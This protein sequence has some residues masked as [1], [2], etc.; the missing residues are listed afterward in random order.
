[1]VSSD[2]SGYILAPQVLA[3]GSCLLLLLGV[4]IGKLITSSRVGETDS[5]SSRTPL[6]RE[7]TSGARTTIIHGIG[8][9]QETGSLHGDER[10]T[11]TGS[12]TDTNAAASNS[13]AEVY[14]PLTLSLQYTRR[15]PFEYLKPLR[16]R[17]PDGIALASDFEQWYGDRR[18]LPAPGLTGRQLDAWKRFP[19]P[20]ASFSPK[21]MEAALQDPRGMVYGGG[22]GGLGNQLWAAATVLAVAI[23]TNRLPVVSCG[24]CY[25]HE[26]LREFHC[27]PTKRGNI[28]V[29]SDVS[30]AWVG[31]GEAPQAAAAD[32]DKYH[33]ATEKVLTMTGWMQ[34]WYNFHNHW[35]SV[36]WALRPRPD[37]QKLAQ[38]FLDAVVRDNNV[39]VTE[40]TRIVT[41]HLRRGDYVGK[42]NIHG[43]L[44]KEYYDRGLAMIRARVAMAEPR[45]AAE[46][47]VVV[48]MTEQENVQ[49]CQENMKWGMAD[50]V[51]VAICAEPKGTRCK[52]EI[53]DM[54]AL[55][56]GDFI[57]IANSTF[58]WWAHFFGQC[59]RLLEG[60]WVG[61]S[62]F[63]AKTYSA[64]Q[65]TVMPPRWYTARLKRAR[66]KTFDL[67]TSDVLVPEPKELFEGQAEIM[68][69]AKD[70]G[71]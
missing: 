57:I 65:A 1:M 14:G 6:S 67:M 13:T 53:V 32:V 62:V 39:T 58:S 30:Q 63:P 2:R 8:L 71:Y 19:G 15:T 64:V 36:C 28:D 45:S 20:P 43:L 31:W 11:S 68:K 51:N 69:T 22:H 21:S 5:V 18:E 7:D 48:V 23:Q 46:G 9:R 66:S 3:L 16:V 59:R 24:S 49:W 70:W 42:A 37:I 52:G 55:A 40:H 38:D 60:W 26:A 35:D 27:V 61:K 54:M 50:G 34:S 29:S 4:N 56:I 10:N 12:T 41:I 17:G 33:H 25:R 44:T 47:L